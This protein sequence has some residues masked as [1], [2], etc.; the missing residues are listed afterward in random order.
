MGSIGNANG[1]EQIEVIVAGKVVETVIEVEKSDG[2]VVVVVE[3]L[4]GGN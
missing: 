2:N 3:N 1:V 4:E